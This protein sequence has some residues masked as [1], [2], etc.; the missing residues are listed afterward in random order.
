MLQWESRR[1]G[2]KG[3][4]EEGTKGKGKDQGRYTAV[5]LYLHL[6]VKV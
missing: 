4:R 6:P 2:V 5:L 3:R 1:V